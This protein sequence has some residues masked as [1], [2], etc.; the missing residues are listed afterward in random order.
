MGSRSAWSAIKQVS[1]IY[2]E[3]IC[4]FECA[5]TQSASYHTT[6]VVLCNSFSNHVDCETD[7]LTDIYISLSAW[8]SYKISELFIKRFTFCRNN[9][10]KITHY[11]SDDKSK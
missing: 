3:P 10:F 11:V 9:S 8:P 7:I 4:S 1:D 5:H 2:S 6:T